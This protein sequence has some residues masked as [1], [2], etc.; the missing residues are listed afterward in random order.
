[1]DDG[2]KSTGTVKEVIAL[3]SNSKQLCHRAGLLLHKVVSNSLKVL[4]SVPS[5]DRA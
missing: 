3:I 1:M 2:L 5:E 4:D